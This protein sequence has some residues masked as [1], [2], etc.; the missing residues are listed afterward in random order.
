MVYRGSE[1]MWAW[2]AHR[3]AGVAVL[4]FVFVHVADTALI[5]WG[6]KYY[7]LF[8][9]L[10]SGPAFRLFEIFLAAALLFHALN[11]V[12]IMIIDFW[13]GGTDIQKPLFYGVMALFLV[14]FIPG[15]YIML[16]PIVR[17]MLGG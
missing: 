2:V 8:V 11:G 6:P 15:A 14:V 10:Y 17:S 1:G 7:N 5:G 3:C 9:K 12:R 4:L 16:S 13:E